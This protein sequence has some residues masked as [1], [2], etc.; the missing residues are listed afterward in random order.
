[1]KTSEELAKN[2]GSSN[3]SEMVNGHFNIKLYVYMHKDIKCTIK[4]T[5][6]TIGSWTDVIYFVVAFHRKPINE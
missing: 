2:K 1:M 4:W 6:Y 3:F 5:K